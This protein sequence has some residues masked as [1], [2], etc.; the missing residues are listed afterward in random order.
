MCRG[1]ISSQVEICAL[2]I[3]SSVMTDRTTNLLGA[4]ALAITDRI[5]E[6]MRRLLDRTGEAGAAI[7]VLGYA[8]GLSVEIL[9]QV[10]GLSHPGA[11]RLIDRLAADGHVERRKAADGRAVAL[12][13]TAEGNALRTK[14]MERRLDRLGSCWPR[15]W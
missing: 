3:Y 4:A 13:L 7:V 14:L 8:P 1:H 15:C 2:R 12:H 11:V 5:G 10:L 9:R 6:D